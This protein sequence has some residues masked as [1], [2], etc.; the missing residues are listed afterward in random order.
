MRPTVA[1]TL[2]LTVWAAVLIGLWYWAADPEPEVTH[3]EE[4]ARPGYTAA[5]QLPADELVHAG[6]Y[7]TTS[8]RP[9]ERETPIPLGGPDTLFGLVVSVFPEDSYTAIRI[10]TCE[11]NWNPAARSRTGDTG[12]F[13]I[14]DI[15][16]APGGVAEGL[17]IA[18]LS[19]PA[20]NVAIARKLYDAQGW[21]PWACY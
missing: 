21:T 9:P 17:T 12:L 11:S 8:T 7:P 16:R 20:T 2:G 18:D 13:Q 5:G 14:N 10:V 4:E 15:H 6:P 1:I 3:V 19:D